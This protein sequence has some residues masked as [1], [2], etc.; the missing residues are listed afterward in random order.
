M[1]WL[2]SCVRHQQNQHFNELSAGSGDEAQMEW[3]STQNLY[4]FLSRVFVSLYKFML[5]KSV[6]EVMNSAHALVPLQR[7]RTKEEVQFMYL[8]NGRK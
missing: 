1:T 4:S 5:F 2:T 3:V 6:W 8:N 7:L